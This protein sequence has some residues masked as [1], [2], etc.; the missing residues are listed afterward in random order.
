MQSYYFI[1]PRFVQ[2][3]FSL[4]LLPFIHT[5]ADLG[6]TGKDETARLITTGH[7]S[8]DLVILEQSILLCVRDK[9]PA[10]SER[11][12]GGVLSS[13]FHSSAA[14]TTGLAYMS[15]LSRTWPLQTRLLI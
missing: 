7:F 1:L 5:I 11:Q 8:L 4:C 2:T 12:L 14:E 13:V 15:S 3:H 10:P 6:S 9:L